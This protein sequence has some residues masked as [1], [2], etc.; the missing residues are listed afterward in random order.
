MDVDE[1]TNTLPTDALNRDAKR[2]IDL[3]DNKPFKDAQDEL[4]SV[5]KY[6]ILF[7]SACFINT[8]LNNILY[9]SDW[10]DFINYFISKGLDLDNCKNI[11]FIAIKSTNYIEIL[12]F[13]DSKKINIYNVMN[14]VKIFF[15]IVYM[16]ITG[17]IN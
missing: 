2:I 12:K 11:M 16:K 1:N 13:L 3:C 15:I 5:D 10:H 4:N 9:K 7:N 6:K 14:K 8:L 17:L